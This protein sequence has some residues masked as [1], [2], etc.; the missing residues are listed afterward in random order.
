M[1]SQISAKEQWN[2]LLHKKG[3][4]EYFSG[5]FVT[6]GIVIVE[7]NESFIIHHKGDHFEL[8]DGLNAKTDY[9]IELNPSNVANM[10]NYGKDEI[11]DENES[12]KIM[13]FLFTPFTSAVFTAPTLNRKIMR[14][15]SGIENHIHVFFIFTRSINLC[16]PYYTV[17][18]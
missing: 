18:E 13:T 1:L 8:E 14:K 6:L 12:Y 11:I 10:V 3:L 7:T 5:I 16:K 4:A 9:V 17:L 2:N 15:L